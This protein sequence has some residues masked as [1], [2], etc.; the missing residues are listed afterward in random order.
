MQHLKHDTQAKNTAWAGRRN[1]IIVLKTGVRQGVRLN[2]SRHHGRRREGT[3]G[4][5]TEVSRTVG[6]TGGWLGAGRPREW[7]TTL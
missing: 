7:R 4:M 5:A 2:R 1:I 6:R 3:E